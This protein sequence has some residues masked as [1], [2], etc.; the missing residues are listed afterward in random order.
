MESIVK[1]I[2]LILTIAACLSATYAQDTLDDG[3]KVAF[4]S[5]VD[6]YLDCISSEAE[7]QASKD[8]RTVGRSKAIKDKCRLER[9]A[10]LEFG[11]IEI[12]AKIVASVEA[13]LVEQNDGKQ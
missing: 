1:Q 4:E 5:V 7:M 8:V 2:V 13:H 6:I 9:D 3:V 12:S 11:D 10:V